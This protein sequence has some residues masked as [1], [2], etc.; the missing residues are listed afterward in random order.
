[1]KFLFTIYNFFPKK[2]SYIPVPLQPVYLGFCIAVHDI[3]F[4][5]LEGPGDDDEHIPFPDPDLLLDLSLDPAQPGHPVNAA[6]PDMVRSHHQF[7]DAKHLPVSFLGEADPDDLSLG[8][9]G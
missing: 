8:S 7:G 2:N 1:M 5:I 4:L 6:D 3:T 9:I